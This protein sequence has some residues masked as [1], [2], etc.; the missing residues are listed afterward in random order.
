M[1]DNNIIALKQ[2]LL[3]IILCFFMHL[4]FFYFRPSSTVSKVDLWSK[5]NRILKNYINVKVVAHL[6]TKFMNMPQKVYV[7]PWV[8][9]MTRREQSE[10]GQTVKLRAAALT[11]CF[12][13]KLARGFF[14]F[15]FWWLLD[16]WEL[17]LLRASYNLGAFL[18]TALYT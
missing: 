17:P 3:G 1:D 10:R 5:T 15:L 9:R 8:P 7:V 18:F 2:Q 6:K 14:R 12:F 13:C 16:L 4:N 11:T